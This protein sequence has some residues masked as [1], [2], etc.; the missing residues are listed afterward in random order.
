MSVSTDAILCYGYNLGGGDGAWELAEEGEY[1]DLELDW[2]GEDDDLVE[3]ATR[4][5]LVAAGLDPDRHYDLA[6]TPVG[7]DFE[8]YC[9]DSYTSYILAAKAI[10]VSRGD[11]EVLDFV[12]LAAETEAGEYDAK[13]ASAIHV[14][15]IT[16]KQDR[17]RWL[18]V[19]YWG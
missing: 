1:G 7:V 12:A 11:C 2:I 16:P 14:L 10:T 3:V 15:G 17:P 8:G 9:S 19:S 13:L 6:M 5:L 18:L 4:R